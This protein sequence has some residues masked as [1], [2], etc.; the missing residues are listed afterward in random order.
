MLTLGVIYYYTIII[1][2]IILYYYILYYILYYYI[3]SYLILYS[4]L[5][6]SSIP[7][8]LYSS[9]PSFPLLL[10]SPQSSPVLPSSNIHSIRVG[11][12]IRLFIYSSPLLIYLPLSS[13]SSSSLLLSLPSFLSS[14][15]HPLIP[16][17]YLS[18]F[19]P[20]SFPEYLSVLR[21]TYLYSINIS[22]TI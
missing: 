9:I 5:L 7:F 3:I 8:L 13:I 12:Y 2:Y 16:I 14:S 10:L 11:T 19:N 22:S 4:S 15:P 6:L 18:I 1:Y 17:G 20:P 21:Y